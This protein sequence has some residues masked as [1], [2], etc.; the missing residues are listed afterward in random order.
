MKLVDRHVDTD[1]LYI[2]ATVVTAAL[3]FVYALNLVGYAGAVRV[4]EIE[5]FIKVGFDIE[6]REGGS[7][8]ILV[9]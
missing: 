5:L 4:I 1:R 9:A 2:V 6:L 8:E 3:F 7:P